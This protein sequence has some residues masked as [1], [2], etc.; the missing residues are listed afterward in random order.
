METANTDQIKSS[1]LEAYR[2]FSNLKPRFLHQRKCN[3]SV[4]QKAN[5][6]TVLRKITAAYSEKYRKLTYIAR[7]Q[8]CTFLFKAGVRYCKHCA[9][10]VT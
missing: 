8:E 7:V 3:V 1:H 5:G 2:S 4:L 9:L 10:R 6:A